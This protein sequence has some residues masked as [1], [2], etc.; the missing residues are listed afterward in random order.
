L[1]S[2]G[3]ETPLSADRICVRP[4]DRVVSPDF[5]RAAIPGQTAAADADLLFVS[6]LLPELATARSA[7]QHASIEAPALGGVGV[8]AVPVFP[9]CVGGGVAAAAVL[10]SAAAAVSVGAAAAVPV[11]AGSAV[12]AAGAPDDMGM[13]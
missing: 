13:A 7:E 9:P 3:T 5:T 4:A 10:V 12:T 8:V 6:A 2:G 11:G 1:H